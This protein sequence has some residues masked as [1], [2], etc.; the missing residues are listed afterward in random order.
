MRNAIESIVLCDAVRTPFCHGTKMKRIKPEKLLA[1]I[2]ESLVNRNSLKGD[3]ISG[4]VTGTVM[5]GWKNPNIARSGAQLAGLP[6]STADYTVQNNCNSAFVGL[7]SALGAISSG[8]GELYLSTGVESMSRYGF[9]LRDLSGSCGSLFE[10]NELQ[11]SGMSEFMNNFQVVDCLE[12][13][14]TD[15]NNQISMIEIGEIMAN[16][17]HISREEQDTYTLDNLKKAV[18][19]VEEKKMSSHIIEIDGIYADSYPLNRKKMIRRPELF[20][21]AAEVFG[22][23]NP[24]LNPQGFFSK[25]KKHLEKLSVKKIDPTVTMYNSSIPGDGAGGCIITTEDF[26]QKAGLTPKFRVINWAVTGVNPVIMGIGPCESTEKLFSDPKTSFAEGLMM[27]DMDQVEIHEAFAAQVLSV[28]K[29]SAR[30]YG[31]KWDRGKI[32]PYGGSLAYTHPLGATNFRMLANAFSW[33][34]ENR[35]A[36]YALLC[37]CAG[38]GQGTSLMLKR[39]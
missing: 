18:V 29:E 32:N 8:L 24:L 30:K 17:F 35:K 20:S 31:R 14:L 34:E 33:F 19:A 26:A 12:E 1:A 22:K 23:E 25:H 6:D 28:F 39:F 5:Q 13:C 37:G 3:Y 2:I 11:K 10:V 4:V 36:E 9:G 15:R 27:D 38:G 16:Y 7:I 21:R